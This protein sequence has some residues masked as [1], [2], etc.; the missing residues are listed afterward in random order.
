MSKNDTTTIERI[1]TM[2]S[3]PPPTHSRPEAADFHT[4]TYEMS[5][6]RKLFNAPKYP[7][8]PK[9]MYYQVPSTPPANDFPKP[10]FPWESTAPKPTRVFADDAPPPAAPS[11]ATP[12]VTTDDEDDD[13]TKTGTMSS[14]TPTIQSSNT[15]P[16]STYTR[17]NAWDEVPEIERYISQ[18]PQNRRAKV[19]VLLNNAPPPSSSHQR[20]SSGDEPMLSPSIEAPSQHRRPSMRLTDFPTEIERPSLPV[21]PAPMRRPSFWGQERDAAGDLPGAEGVPD[22]SA[23]DPS[24]KLAELQRRQSD[25]LADGP[26]S[27]ARFIPDRELLGSSSAP[28]TEVED[29]ESAERIPT[30]GSTQGAMPTAFRTVD[31]NRGSVFR[32]REIAEAT[33]A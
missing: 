23:W 10:I 6:D 8:P 13:V 9:D 1:L 26:A 19:Q 22:Q 5:E 21:T 17:T 31:F 24:A 2:H 14:S 7:E 33:E 29:D 16:F 11:E 25:M 12:S 27:P 3:N 4:E 20:N 30:A 15:E 18:L 28:L 32:N